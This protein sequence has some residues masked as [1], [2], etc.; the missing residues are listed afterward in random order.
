MVD[1]IEVHEKNQSRGI[2]KS[3]DFVYKHNLGT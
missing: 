2:E 3:I 1:I